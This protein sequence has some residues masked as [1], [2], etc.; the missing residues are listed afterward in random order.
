MVGAGRLKK[1]A[2]ACPH[3]LSDAARGH[4]EKPA[5]HPVPGPPLCVWSVDG[6]DRRGRVLP[7]SRTVTPLPDLFVGLKG[8]PNAPQS[9]LHEI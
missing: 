7:R 6:L 3:P 4:A 1:D 2:L 9:L 8:S 5:W